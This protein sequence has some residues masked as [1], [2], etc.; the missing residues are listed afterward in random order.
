MPYLLIYL[1]VLA[2]FSGIAVFC[3]RPRKTA[4]N[5]NHYVKKYPLLFCLFIVAH[6]AKADEV[7]IDKVYDP[8]VEQMER[9]LEWRSSYCN[10]DGHSGIEIH[11]LVLGCS[12]TPAWFAEI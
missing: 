5:M 12:Y 11:R 1:L 7:N 3:I 10:Y 8:H 4:I 9:E 2:G 6:F